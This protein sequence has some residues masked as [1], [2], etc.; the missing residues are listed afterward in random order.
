M[1]KIGVSEDSSGNEIKGSQEIELDFL[2]EKEKSKQTQSNSTSKDTGNKFWLW[3][4]TCP[5][6]SDYLE[7]NHVT[8]LKLRKKELLA[9]LSKLT[10]SSAWQADLSF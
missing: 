8:F 5:L 2:K 3:C 9:K 10:I 7:L 4:S 6:I 1:R